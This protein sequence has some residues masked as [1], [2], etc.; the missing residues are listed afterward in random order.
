MISNFLRFRS[1]TASSG[2][3]DSDRDSDASVSRN[4]LAGNSK[5]LRKRGR[6]PGRGAARSSA[7]NTV[8]AKGNVAK[9]F[10]DENASLSSSSTTSEV[11]NK[12]KKRPS[13]AQVKIS[14]FC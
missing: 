5:S 14:F 8:P 10:K 9:K 13:L 4:S 1:N 12:K 3:N 11:T 2:D 7:G 6:K